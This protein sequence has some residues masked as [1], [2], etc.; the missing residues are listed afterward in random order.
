MLTHDVVKCL[1]AKSFAKL[2]ESNYFTKS[3]DRYLYIFCSLCTKLF[4]FGCLHFLLLINLS[5]SKQ[6]IFNV[7]IL[8]NVR[9]LLSELCS[10]KVCLWTR[11]DRGRSSKIFLRIVSTIRPQF[12]SNKNVIWVQCLR[13]LAKMFWQN[14][15]DLDK[16]VG[17][18]QSWL[19]LG[20][21]TK[22][23]IPKNI[24]SST[25]MFE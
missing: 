21:I 8:R 10:F 22:S 13:S 16:F 18:G 9:N 15:L 1:I 2:S 3:Q 6:L 20:K 25:A 12:K 4:F 24:W 14:S 19:D 11:R 23:C 17:F 5:Y 7:K